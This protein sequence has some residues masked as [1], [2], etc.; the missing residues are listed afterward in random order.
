MHHIAYIILSLLPCFSFCFLALPVEKYN[1][2]QQALLTFIF[3]CDLGIPLYF[4]GTYT[5]AIGMCTAVISWVSGLK[6]AVWLFCMP[7][8]E[9]HKRPFYGTLFYW[10]DRPKSTSS[11]SVQV[12][13]KVNGNAGPP[14]KPT[15]S[16]LPSNQEN[17]TRVVSLRRFLWGFIKHEV[18]FSLLHVAICSLDRHQ[19]IAVF[20]HAV[21][22]FQLRSTTWHK[23]L[24]PSAIMSS[25]W[26]CS[27]FS[28]YLQGQM[29]LT[30]D[31]FLITFGITY[32][33]LPWLRMKWVQQGVVKDYIEQAAD[34]PPAFDS[35]WSSTSLRD[36]WSNRWHKFYNACFYR[37]AYRPVRRLCG[38]IPLLRKSLPTWAVF[39]LSGL[40]H[41]YYLYCAAGPALYFSGAGGWQLMFFSIQPIGILI[42]DAF[43]WTGWPGRLWAITWMVFMS[44]LFVIP[45]LLCNYFDTLVV[46]ASPLDSLLFSKFLSTAN[47]DILND[48]S[49]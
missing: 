49:S 13:D 30:Y 31:L 42:G 26:L 46:R 45:F 37:L 27:M 20:Q 9:R 11:A 41:E 16:S 1:A 14:S 36:Y 2:R 17:Q 4:A 24:T 6:M 7:Q 39:V 19:A 22:F 18:T 5:P 29:Q 44:H 33:I 40:M 10:R 8:E 12:H 43:F 15:T 3:V 21:D 38:G 35:P 47:S 23:E 48:L 34:M 25:F 28:V 32:H